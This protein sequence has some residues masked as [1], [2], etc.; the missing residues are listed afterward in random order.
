MK[1]LSEKTKLL[2]NKF[3]LTKRRC[4]NSA[5]DSKDAKQLDETVFKDAVDV[6]SDSDE[7]LMTHANRIFAK[8][9]VTPPEP[10]PTWE[11]DEEDDNKNKNNSKQSK[12]RNLKQVLCR[13]LCVS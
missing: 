9:G 12:S 3:Q 5:K 10:T 11:E 8:Y 1:K 7:E 4:G 2:S 13:F 6:I